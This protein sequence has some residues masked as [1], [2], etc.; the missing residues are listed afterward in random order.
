MAVPD[1]DGKPDQHDWCRY[2]CSKGCA[3]YKDR[4]QECRDFHCMYLVSEQIPD[5]WYPKLS[6]IVINPKLDDSE[7]AFVSFVVDPSYPTRWRE[8]PWISDIKKMALA[9]IEGRH[10]SRWTTV[11]MIRDKSIVIGK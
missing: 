10:G 11:V 3:I 4:P 6:K 8:E 2:A 7:G 9:G 1:F 5:Y